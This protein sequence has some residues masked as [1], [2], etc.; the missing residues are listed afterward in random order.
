MANESFQCIIV[1][2]RRI[3]AK[4]PIDSVD[5]DH[6]EFATT[7]SQRPHAAMPQIDR[8]KGGGV[9]SYIFIYL[10]IASEVRRMILIVYVS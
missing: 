7:A 3:H 4:S 9:G 8:G 2:V 1:R 10:I 6:S 5:S